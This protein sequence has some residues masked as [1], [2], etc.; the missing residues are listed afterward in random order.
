MALVARK[1]GNGRIRSWI[2]WNGDTRVKSWRFM[3]GNSR[4]SLKP[5]GRKDRDGF[6]TLTSVPGEARYLR[7][8]GLSG[9]GK[10]LGYSKV[11]PVR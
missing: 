1:T 5:I 9:K 8:I 11:R 3:A 10:R 2:S 4:K 7:V 6:E